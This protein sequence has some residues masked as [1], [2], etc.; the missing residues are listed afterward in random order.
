MSKTFDATLK[1]L[2]E[3]DCAGWPTLI[4]L[5]PQS[6]AIIDADISTVSTATDKVIRLSEPDELLAVDFQ[7]GPLTGLPRRTCK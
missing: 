6:S 5:S 1:D 2:L 7:A 4:G 3:L